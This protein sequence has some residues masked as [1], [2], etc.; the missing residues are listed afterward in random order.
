MSLL[1][2]TS[3]KT[4]LAYR[5]EFCCAQHWL[6]N[7][8]QKQLSLITWLLWRSAQDFSSPQN[9]WHKVRCHISLKRLRVE[10]LR[11]FFSRLFIKS[12]A[13][14]VSEIWCWKA[15]DDRKW[16]FHCYQIISCCRIDLLKFSNLKFIV[17]TSFGFCDCV[18]PVTLSPRSTSFIT[19][20]D[21][22]NQRLYILRALTPKY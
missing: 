18:K 20:G 19:L 11:S 16:L 7:S 22:S 15:T 8:C 6:I 13:Y 17:K 2:F 10:S 21:L 3:S 14:Y 12:T 5:T 1:C 4:L 9:I